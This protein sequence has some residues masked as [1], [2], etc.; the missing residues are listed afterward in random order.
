YCFR[1]NSA[2]SLPAVLPVLLSLVCGMSS[3]RSIGTGVPDLFFLV[4]RRCLSI[5]I[6]YRNKNVT[7]KHVHSD[8]VPEQEFVLVSRM[9]MT[10]QLCD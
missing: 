4:V 1:S 2:A 9:K 8:T 6:F 3:A 7:G 5:D 10:G